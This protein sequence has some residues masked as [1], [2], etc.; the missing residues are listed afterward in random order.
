MIPRARVAFEPFPPHVDMQ[1]EVETIPRFEFAQSIPCDYINQFPREAL[2]L[3]IRAWVVQL[4]RPLVITGFD[5]LLDKKVFSEKWL[6]QTYGNQTYDA[7]DL[8]K[9]VNLP[10]SLGHYLRNMNKLTDRINDKTFNRSNIQRLYLK[11]I[12]CPKEWH[13]SLEQLLPST[14]FYL[15]QD[16]LTGQNSPASS[17]PDMPKTPD[18]QTVARAGDLM[19]SL[20]EAMRAQNLMCYIGHEGTYTPAHQEMCASLGQNLMVEASDGSVEN[21]QP[22]RPGSSIWLMTET[23][24]RRIV[25]EYWLSM[26]GHDLDLENHFASLQAWR[27]A[28][29]KTYVVEQKPGDLILVP[30]L[31]AHQVWNRG[32]R[33]MKVAW[34]RTTVD[35]LE[36]AFDEA[37]SHARM[38]CRDEQYK[39]KAIVYFTLERYSELLCKASANSSHPEM[40][41]LREDFRRLFYLYSD[42][43]LS[44]CFSK[45]APKAKEIDFEK[46][47][48][49]ITCSYCRCNIFNRF[50]TCPW[51]VG[52]G[53]ETYDI[54]MDCYVLGR[55]CQC[56]S[57]LKWVEQFPWEQ[58]TGRYETWRRQIAEWTSGSNAKQRKP[59]TLLVARS[60]LGRKSLAEICQEQLRAR[61]WV[62]YKNPPA[63]TRVAT[64][65]DEEEGENNEARAR[66]K[67]KSNGN[68]PA[69]GKARCHMCRSQEEVWKLASCEK[70]KLHYCYSSLFR[71][72]DMLPLDAM[73]R[74]HWLC[75]R[76][77]GIC[78]CAACRHDETMAPYK[79]FNILMGHDTQKIADPRSI[80]S[81]VNMRLS[82]LGLLKTFGDDNAERL[83]RLQR[84]ETQRSDASLVEQDI[85]SDLEALQTGSVHDIH[86]AG[87][88]QLPAQREQGNGTEHHPPHTGD[89]A[90]DAQSRPPGAIPIDPALELD[91]S[92][93]DLSGFGEDFFEQAANAIG[94]G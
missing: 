13:Q 24:D 87:D 40:Q 76:C 20:P 32:T 18:G 22:T 43:L 23:K 34:N 47:E 48:S 56:V 46:F 89:G 64:P 88:M 73:Q 44:E 90:F 39:N 93:M 66:K 52:E 57:K 60:E 19:S 50:L 2:N 16:P 82:N 65:S 6:M 33:T 36:A 45:N 17:T 80:E 49:N 55:S 30:P 81:L 68:K 15:N 84:D 8:G 11:D 26:L 41:M 4:G 10:L 72:F 12:D 78:N 25:S 94:F 31:A 51:C 74:P 67:R 14:L 79:P 28:P 35:T 7:R 63:V 77:R 62:D 37:L 54:C 5:K 27:N 85:C 92:W 38:I 1:K 21:G 58:L 91:G 53:N 59:P 61:P 83:E 9:G 69:P 75:P 3:Y 42:I 70:C 86:D 71:S 29:F